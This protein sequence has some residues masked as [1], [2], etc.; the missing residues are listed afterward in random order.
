MKKRS[1]GIISLWGLIFILGYVFFSQMMQPEQEEWQVAPLPKLT[2]APIILRVAYA[3]NP[4]FPKMDKKQLDILLKTAKALT[5]EHFQIEIEFEDIQEIPIEALFTFLPPELADI[6]LMGGY[7]FRSGQKVD[8][9]RLI[10]A[11]TLS[12]TRQKSSLQ[13][14]VNYA[15]PYLLQELETVNQSSF[16]KSLAET[17]LYR[18]Q[19]WRSLK[20]TDNKPVID[21]SLYNEWSMWA[22]LG[23]GQLPYDLVLTNQLIASVEY[24]DQDVHSALRGG[25]V[26][27][28]TSYNKNSRYGT[29]IFWSTF[30]YSNDYETLIQLRGGERYKEEEAAHLAGAALTHEI[31]HQLFRLG[32]PFGSAGCVMRPVELFKFR[33]WYTQLDANQCGIESNPGMEVNSIPILYNT[34]W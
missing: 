14:I 23:Y 20:A 33:Q 26:A 11:M 32:H 9:Q 28:T 31:G 4:R 8:Q 12:L 27:G 10:D 7:D 15:R 13:E 3:I 5:Q 34:I 2:D 1:V 29:Y 24:Y 16:A 22:A 18:F 19:Q 21:D 17:L 25:V 6:Q 30:L